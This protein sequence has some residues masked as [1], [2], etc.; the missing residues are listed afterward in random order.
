MPELKE[1]NPS[2]QEA[3]KGA[4]V[5]LKYTYKFRNQ[6]VELDDD[7]LYGIEASAARS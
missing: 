7:W 6:F 4:L 5:C 3:E 1:D 2:R